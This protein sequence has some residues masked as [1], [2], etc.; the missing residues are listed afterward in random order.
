AA[1]PKVSGKTALFPRNDRPYGLKCKAFQ[2]E[3]ALE[4]FNFE[5]GETQRNRECRLKTA[6]HKGFPSTSRNDLSFPR[7]WGKTVL[8][9]ANFLPSLPPGKVAPS[10]PCR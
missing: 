2:T 3:I 8:P 5:K 4:R 9:S 10:A 1:R 7:T 6:K